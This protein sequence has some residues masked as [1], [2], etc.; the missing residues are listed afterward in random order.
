MPQHDPPHGSAVVITPW[1]L[2][3]HSFGS[4]R[5]SMSREHVVVV[6]HE[7]CLERTEVMSM[8]GDEN[9]QNRDAARWWIQMPGD[10]SVEAALAPHETKT[11]PVHVPQTMTSCSTGSR[12]GRTARYSSS[13]RSPLPLNP[14]H[15]ESRPSNHS[16]QP[17][18]RNIPPTSPLWSARRSKTGPTKIWS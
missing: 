17:S 8:D 15:R 11:L 16:Q 18:T 10:L 1:L 7:V 2:L 3:S 14:A 5:R 6:E 9:T 12:A 13:S 4:A